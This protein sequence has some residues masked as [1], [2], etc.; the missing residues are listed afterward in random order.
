M[1]QGEELPSDFYG[2]TNHFKI[3]IPKERHS[4]VN[5]MQVESPTNEKAYHKNDIDF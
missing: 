4:L 1:N 3:K 5:N 2:M